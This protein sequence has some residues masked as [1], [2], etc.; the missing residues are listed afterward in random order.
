MTV[1]VKGDLREELRAFPAFRRPFAVRTRYGCT[2]RP[3]ASHG[4]TAFLVI[5]RPAKVSD[6]LVHFECVEQY[7]FDPL[8]RGNIHQSL[9]DLVEGIAITQN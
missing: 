2:A 5:D 8:T 7:G 1:G 9:F 6:E 3:V 4:E